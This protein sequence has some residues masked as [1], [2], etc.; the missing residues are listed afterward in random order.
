MNTPKQGNHQPPNSNLFWL[1]VMTLFGLSCVPS[2]IQV[3]MTPTVTLTPLSSTPTPTQTPTAMV[4]ALPTASR[5]PSMIDYQPLSGEI[6]EYLDQS[7]LGPQFDMAIG[8]V[9]IQTGQSLSFDG[10]TRHYALSTFKGP[11]AAFYLWL[12]ENNRLDPLPSDESYLVP[13][14]TES[15]NPATSCVLKRVGGLAPFNDWLADQG[16]SR[17]NNFIASWQSWACKENNQ[18]YI[19]PLD[20]RYI[21]GDRTLNLPGDYALSRCYPTYNNCDKAFA[22]LELAQLYVRLYQGEVL[23]A[24]NTAQWLTWMEKDRGNSALI[25]NVPADAPVRAYIK[26]GFRARGGDAPVHFYHEAGI[27]ETPYG[28]YALAVFTQGNPDWPASKPLAKVG[29]IIYD[30]FVKAKEQP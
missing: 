22:P 15:D 14:L 29:L 10:E 4:A 5:T 19:L 18:A 23:D 8:F 25:K 2:S 20:L 21:Q 27:I 12:I 9:D 30:Y 7:G 11:L 1:I 17:Q 26:N 6:Q 16:L 3:T 28:V 13:M 24:K